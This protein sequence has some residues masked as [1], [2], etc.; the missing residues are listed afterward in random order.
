MYS[1]GMRLGHT[2]PYKEKYFSWTNLMT[3][4][5]SLPEQSGMR[6]IFGTNHPSLRLLIVLRRSEGPY[7][8]IPPLVYGDLGLFMT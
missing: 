8:K 6:D 7:H 2:D 5:S 4:L 1:L 3:V